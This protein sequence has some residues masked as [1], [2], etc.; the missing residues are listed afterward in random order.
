MAELQLLLMRHGAG[1]KPGQDPE[2]VQPGSDGVLT[3]QGYRDAQAVGHVLAETL[4]WSS[5]PVPGV[6]CFYAGPSADSEAEA[7]LGP[8]PGSE[9]EATARVIAEQ[10]TTAGIHTGTPQPFEPILPDKIL[11]S[12][13]EPAAIKTA[14]RGV[15]DQVRSADSQLVLVAGSLA[16]ESKRQRR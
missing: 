6:R 7:T 10:L 5:R 13:P 1:I 4:N 2:K 16:C 15:E 12:R 11:A 9:P 3:A 14:A 8:R